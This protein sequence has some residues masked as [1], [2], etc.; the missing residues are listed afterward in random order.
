MMMTTSE[1]ASSRSAIASLITVR[2]IRFFSRASVVG[3]VQTDLRSWAR[4]V[5]EAGSTSRR[6]GVVVGDTLVDLGDAGQSTVPSSFQFAC[7]QAVLRVGGIVLTER[8]VGS[9]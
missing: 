3:A 2:T 6:R 8:P 1:V 9:V 5:K 7:N 4:L